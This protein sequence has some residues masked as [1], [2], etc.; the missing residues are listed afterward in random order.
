MSEALAQATPCSTGAAQQRGSQSITQS[1]ATPLP[2][3]LILLLPFS[4]LPFFVLLYPPLL[5]LTQE[6]CTLAAV[7]SNEMFFTRSIPGLSVTR[8]TRYLQQHTTPH[9]I[10]ALK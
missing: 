2:S 1:T 8:P 10:T 5:P 4:A 7:K 6:A 3:Y 9:H